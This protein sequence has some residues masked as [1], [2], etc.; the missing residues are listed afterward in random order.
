MLE[1]LKTPDDLKKLDEKELD[2]LCGEIRKTI[3]E[4][5]ARNGGHLAPNLGTVE[6]TVALHR[7]FDCPSDKIFF[8][9]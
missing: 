9:V 8:D 6:L 4:T 5:V 1:K 7:V 3:I 2:A